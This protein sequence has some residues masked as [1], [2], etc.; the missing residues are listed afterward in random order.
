[1]SAT[2][3]RPTRF[4]V[5]VFPDEMREDPASA[6]DASTWVVT[7]EDRGLGGWAVVYGDGGVRVRVL[8][9]EGEWDYE[10]IPSSRTA[11]WLA[12]HR[13]TRAEALDMARQQAPLI[14]W[15]GLTAVDVLARH[16]GG[17]A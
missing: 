11:E 10:P 1:M 17:A 12:M 7:V 13:F 6:M 15:N 3:V 14:T 4:E 8:S 5:S 9:A 2:Y 16:S